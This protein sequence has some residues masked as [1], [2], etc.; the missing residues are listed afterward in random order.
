MPKHN[1]INHIV[2]NGL[3]A[4]QYNARSIG[5]HVD[6]ILNRCKEMEEALKK[7]DEEKNDGARCVC[8]KCG[9]VHPYK[10]SK[11][12]DKQAKSIMADHPTGNKRPFPV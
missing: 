1:D 3:T 12:E 8:P 6:Y 10:G 5:R 11:S 9:D 4:I 7:V 2:R